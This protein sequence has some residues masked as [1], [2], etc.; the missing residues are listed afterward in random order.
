MREK[1]FDFNCGINVYIVFC[2]IIRTFPLSLFL[3]ILIYILILLQNYSTQNHLQP[4]QMVIHNNAFNIQS[5]N[6]YFLVLTNKFKRGFVLKIISNIF[7]FLMK[8]SKFVFGFF[9]VFRIFLFSTNPFWST[10]S[11]IK[12]FC[13]YLGFQSFLQLT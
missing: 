4:L 7:N 10:L 12:E 11:F 9:S 1:N 6:S 8:Y 3:T 2:L 13:K 5:F